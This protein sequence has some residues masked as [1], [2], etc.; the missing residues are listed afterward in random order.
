MDTPDIHEVLFKALDRVDTELKQQTER[1][2]RVE[3]MFLDHKN[4]KLV[5]VVD[6]SDTRKSGCDALQLVP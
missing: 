6:A 1:Q 2:L 5:E 3:G 4:R